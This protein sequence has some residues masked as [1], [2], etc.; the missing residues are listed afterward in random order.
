MKLVV[1]LLG[2]LLLVFAYA[3]G[4]VFFLTV[5]IASVYVIAMPWTTLVEHDL[6]TKIFVCFLGVLMLFVILGGI[7]LILD[8]MVPPKRYLSPHLPPKAIRPEP[9]Q[10]EKKTKSILP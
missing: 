9:P 7:Y 3:L 8:D 10:Q 1:K 6:E 5:L 4:V 2:G